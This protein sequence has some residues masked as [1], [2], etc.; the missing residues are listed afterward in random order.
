MK[1]F[2]SLVLVGTLTIGAMTVNGCNSNNPSEQPN[3]QS[4]GT[5]GGNG[6]FGENPA[7]PGEHSGERFNNSTPT[8]Q[9][10]Q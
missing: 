1:D 9:P 10:A 3:G 8:T 2:M 5:A 4:N 6:A 7:Q